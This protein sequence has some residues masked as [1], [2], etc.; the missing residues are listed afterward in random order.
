MAV[1]D[2]MIRERAILHVQCSGTTSGRA[3]RAIL[4]LTAIM[5][6][7]AVAMTLWTGYRVSNSL[8]GLH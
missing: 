7:S 8:Y 1:E 2:D 4:P 5:Y 3:G 6:T